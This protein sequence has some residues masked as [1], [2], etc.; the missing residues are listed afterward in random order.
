M[1]FSALCRRGFAD[2]Q[3]LVVSVGV[4]FT[5][6]ADT[7]GLPHTGMPAVDPADSIVSRES[8]AVM[9]W[10][11]KGTLAVSWSDT[12]SWTREH[13][14]LE[15]GICLSAWRALQ[16]REGVM[17]S[18]CGCHDPGESLHGPPSCQRS[19]PLQD[20]PQEVR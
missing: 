5:Y 12:Y 20:T 2:I 1:F 18:G 4:H 11:G 17:A 16:A 13:F 15:G 10:G 3:M 9:S 6:N 19:Q 14:P 8:S 7:S